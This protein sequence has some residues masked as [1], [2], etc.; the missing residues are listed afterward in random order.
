MVVDTSAV[1][2]ILLGEPEAERIARALVS[3][4]RPI[5]SALTAVETGI[6][7]EARKGANGSR[8]WELLAFK[9]NIE[10]VAFSSAQH[11]L[12]LEAWRK[13]GKGRHDAALNLGDCCAYAL[14]AHTGQPLLC[15]GAD[16][17]ATDIARVEW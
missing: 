14:A 11:T 9:A 1:M 10:F 3:D 16:F 15:K 12:A 2:A 5:M 8:E 17:A 4:P 13:Y 6:V 7:I